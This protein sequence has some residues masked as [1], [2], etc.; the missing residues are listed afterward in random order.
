MRYHCYFPHI[1]L[2][3]LLDQEGGSSLDHTQSTKCSWFHWCF[4]TYLSV[5]S[6]TQFLIYVAVG[7]IQT[8]ISLGANP[9][10]LLAFGNKLIHFAGIVAKPNDHFIFWVFTLGYSVHLWLFLSG[11]YLSSQLRYMFISWCFIY[12]YSSFIRYKL[13]QRSNCQLI[14]TS[15]RISMIYKLTFINNFRI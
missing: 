14:E 11:F 13:L 8:K 15:Q 5:F 9:P 2:I 12:G 7:L 1:R 4:G 10:A 3:N 6:E